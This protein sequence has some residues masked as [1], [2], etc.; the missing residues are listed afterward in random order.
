MTVYED[1]EPILTESAD[2]SE[3]GCADCG[4][5]RAASEAGEV[6]AVPSGSRPPIRSTAALR[7][8]WRD[9]RCATN[10]MVQLRLFG[11]WNTPVNPK[12]VEAWRALESTLTAAGY[13]VHRAWVYVCRNITGQR[14]ASLHAYGLAIDIDHAGPRCNVNNP[15]PDKREVKFSTGATKQERCRDV[16]RGVADTAFTP[17]QVAAVEAIRTLDG[18]QVFAWGGR[19][20]TTKDTMHFQINVTPEEL[21]RG[22]AQETIGTSTTSAAEFDEADPSDE[23]L[24]AELDQLALAEERGDDEWLEDEEAV[25]GWRGTPE[26]IAFRNRVMTAH[27]KRSKRAKG[28]PFPSR[29]PD[30]LRDIP[31]TDKV[32][33]LPATAD[34]A[35]RLIAAANSA[36]REA[37]ARG[38]RDALSTERITATSGYRT[39]ARQRARWLELFPKYYN[40]SQAARERLAGGPHSEAAVAH[41]IAGKSDGGFGIP[42]RIAAPG[43]SNHENGIAVDFYQVRTPRLPNSTA[44]HD[45][46]KWR[47][48]WFY[49][50]LTAEGNGR[51]FGFKQLVSEEWH[52]EYQG[53]P[54]SQEEAPVSERSGGKAWNYRSRVAGT[55]VAVFVPPAAFGK[56]RVEVMVYVHGLLSPCGALSSVPDGLITDEKFAVGRSVRDAGAPMIVVAP[57][58]QE[59]NDRTWSAHG[60]NKP[61]RLNLLVAEAID[62]VGNRLGGT[63]T[64]S[65]LVVAGHSRAFGVLYPLARA[66]GD[67]DQRSG[68]LATLSA[69]WLLDATYGTV[70]MDDFK[71]LVSAHPG[72]A[73]RI[74]YR[75][76]SPTDKF[77]GRA[78]KGPVEL[79]PVSARTRHCAVPRDVLGSLI[80]ELSAPTTVSAAEGETDELLHSIGEWDTECTGEVSD[81]EWPSESGG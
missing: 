42:A 24:G 41:M 14:A 15:T 34:S 51:R 16:Q 45:R 76:G 39:T 17:G 18:H 30:E 77:R 32:R 64:V 54:A 74:V 69:M 68:A 59:G 62:Q 33:T 8:A 40:Q 58:L 1:Y 67:A 44:D 29:R 60:L 20:P 12:T 71:A 7:T 61:K 21:A 80:A 31:G 26:Q 13:D 37:R 43:Y 47:E 36:L 11:K 79:R 6:A 23:T 57:L 66:H 56:D 9:Y 46:A 5:R 10:R 73:V 65:R 50:W 25:G 38:D 53:Q 27:L 72:L 22:I 2:T 55:K 49:K 52:W 70:P 78:L 48:T 28:N 4:H 3:C 63:R 81:D 35:G 19:W 75:V